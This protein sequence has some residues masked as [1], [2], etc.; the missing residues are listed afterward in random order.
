MNDSAFLSLF[1]QKMKEDS[2]KKDLYGLRINLGRSEKDIQDMKARIKEELFDVLTLK[3]RHSFDIDMVLKRINNQF[4]NFGDS[5]RIAIK[6]DQ[7]AL[8]DVSISEEEILAD[9]MEIR[10]SKDQ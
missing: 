6:E 10:Y 3:D 7:K 8:K 9:V 5:S 4:N 2:I 1:Q